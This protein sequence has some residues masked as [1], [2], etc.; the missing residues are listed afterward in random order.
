MKKVMII[1]IMLSLFSSIFTGNA[2][3]QDNTLNSGID[4]FLGKK[5]IS[6]PF[7][8]SLENAK[9]QPIDVEIKFDTHVWAK[10]EQ[11]HA[12]RIAVDDGS[13]P[14]RHGLPL[15]LC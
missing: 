6:I 7:D 10:D 13:G 8:T 3:S 2:F 11:N 14:D 9:F 1:F 15:C 4:D 12:V 5:E